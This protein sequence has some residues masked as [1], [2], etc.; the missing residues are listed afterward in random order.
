MTAYHHSPPMN[1][2]KAIRVAR[3]C[4]NDGQP[5]GFDLNKNG[6]WV[7]FCP[8]KDE[9]RAREIIDDD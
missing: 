8:K 3:E 4:L 1:R 6:K 5:F 9:E 7:F 2:A